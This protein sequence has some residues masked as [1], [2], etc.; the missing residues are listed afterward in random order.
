MFSIVA[1]LS[2]AYTAEMCAHA[3]EDHIQLT[4][5]QS[6]NITSNN[7]P[8]EYQTFFEYDSCV[9]AFATST[10]MFRIKVLDVQVSIE[11]TVG[12][13]AGISPSLP[14]TVYATNAAAK[15]PSRGNHPRSIYVPSTPIGAYMWVV[16]GVADTTIS[17]PFNQYS[18]IK[19]GFM[20]EISVVKDSGVFL[21]SNLFCT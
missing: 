9:R 7:Y 15:M 5:R 18:T 13:G 1:N 20:L 12:I 3:L 14:L 17:R 11:D 6:V 16:F 4:F 10:G 8:A 21:T 19:S 2:I